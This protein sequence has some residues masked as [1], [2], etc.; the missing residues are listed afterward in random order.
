MR[1][2]TRTTLAGRFGSHCTLMGVRLF[3]MA[4]CL[5][6]PG[7][8]SAA[9]QT[10][11]VSFT[12][13]GE[14]TFTVPM[15]VSTISV[16][17]VGAAG[18]TC[19]PAGGQGASVAGTFAVQ[20]GQQL[21]VGVAGPGANCVGQGGAGA[22]GVGG[23]GSGGAG[24]GPGAG[25]TGAGGGGASE[26]GSSALSPAYAP[27]LLIVAAGGGGAGQLGGG[28]G[29]N[30][31][32]PGQSAAFGSGGGSG[33]ATAGGAG[34]TDFSGSQANGQAGGFGLGGAGGGAGLAWYGGGGGGGGYYGGG[35]GAGAAFPLG[36][37]GGGMPAGAGGGGGSSFLAA[38][39]TNTSRPTPTA[40]PASVT[41]TYAVPL[42]PAATF[43]TQ[44]L[45]FPRTRAQAV[46]PQ[47]TLTVT[48]SGA[49][50]LVISGV[51]TGGTNPGDY[52]IDD[53]C[54]QPVAPGSSCQ[55]GVRFAPQAAGT[56][57]ATLTVLSNAPTAPAAVTL[58]GTGG[59]PGR[60]A[61]GKQDPAG[62]AGQVVCQHSVLGI[63]R[64][65][66]ECALGAYKIHGHTPPAR[67]TVVHN[68]QLVARGTLHPARGAVIHHRLSL[69][70]GS[71]T[72]IISTGH[73]SGARA[74]VRLPFRVR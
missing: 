29:G 11:T 51:Q 38:T 53:V 32:S 43:S 15:G 68:G 19:G 63:A 58:S 47:L 45:A 67:F 17:A 30:A 56:R 33:G 73:G 20:P 14:S 21:A 64:C 60:G 31:D 18:G 59:R 52:L 8:A 24:S 7:L 71:Y 57:T 28:A 1:V 13:P 69:R 2:K 49:A 12:S 26:V 41:I 42:E 37:A 5:V 55:I 50:P 39:A 44:S 66:I 16:T 48:N 40:S 62:S 74:L 65:E 23:G 27:S 54:Q 6:S 10:A 3:V 4:V 36:G 72:L 22:G 34:G 9:P 61:G 35:G 70:P 46:S 25:G